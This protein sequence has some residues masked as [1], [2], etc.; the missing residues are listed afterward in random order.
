MD[1]ELVNTYVE[2][3]R[4]LIH[5]LMSK[6]VMLES[7]LS[8]SE[9]YAAKAAEATEKLREKEEVVKKLN[10]QIVTLNVDNEKLKKELNAAELNL[11]E[12]LQLVSDQRSTINKLTLEK[13]S[14]RNKAEKLKKKAQ[15]MVLEETK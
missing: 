12:Q 1:V 14:Q 5:D 11:R 7:R 4:D 10:D 2:K 15:E 8:I 6:N 13:E 3:Q 9:K